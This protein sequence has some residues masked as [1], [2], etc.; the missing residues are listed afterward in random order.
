V[1]EKIRYESMITLYQGS[2]SGEIELVGSAKPRAEWA[3]TKRSVC[4]L[5]RVRKSDKAATLLESTPFDLYQGT[6]YFGD[7]YSLLYL[8]AGLEQYVVMCEQNEDCEI[9]ATYKQIASTFS[10]LGIH[11]RFIAVEL[12]G[13]CDPTPV[14]NPSLT[15]TSDTVERALA[16]AEHLINGRGATS[17]VD[18]IHTAFHAFLRVVCSKASIPVSED[19]SVTHLFKAIRGNHP[20]FS[21]NGPQS[22]QIER[23]VRAMSAIIDCLN[24]LRNNASLAHPNGMLLEQ[25]EAM[26]VI[27]GTRTLLHYLNS[28]LGTI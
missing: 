22:D 28:K 25:A 6:N 14:K 2:G 9:R 1:I 8:L 20:K 7:Q 12:D 19:A 13:K 17:G 24:P 3:E 5:L 15:F 27:N 21:D 16:D 26:L 10:E 4:R 11:I 23:V 18:R